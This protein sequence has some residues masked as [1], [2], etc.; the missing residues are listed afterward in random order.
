MF[1]TGRKDF[2]S[3]HMALNTKMSSRKPSKG[4]L[5]SSTVFFNQSSFR[6]VTSIPLI[7][8]GYSPQ[9]IDIVFVTKSNL[10][11]SKAAVVDV[12]I[13]KTAFAS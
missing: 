7:N 8:G 6:S 12:Y 13:F 11:E 5:N 3:K 1:S 10:R 9:N 2:N 4:R